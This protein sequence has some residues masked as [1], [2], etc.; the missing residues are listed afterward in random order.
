MDIQDDFISVGKKDKPK[1]VL[2][3]CPTPI[4]NLH[5]WT[6]RQDKALFDADVIACED[7]RLTGLLIKMLS[8]KNIRSELHN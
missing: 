7:T 1:G 4:G 5:D 8:Q 2:T 3:I 6:L